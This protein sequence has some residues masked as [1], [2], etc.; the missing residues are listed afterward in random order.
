[1]NPGNRV[2]LRVTL[3]DAMAALDLAGGPVEDE[4]MRDPMA[5]VDDLVKRLMGN[6]AEARF[7]FIQNNSK[8]VEEI[9]I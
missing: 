2:L 6:N 3:P 8:F 5:E 4:D 1:M 7:D 9:D